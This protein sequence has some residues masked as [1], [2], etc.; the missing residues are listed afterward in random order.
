MSLINIKSYTGT[1]L[2]LAPRVIGRLSNAGNPISSKPVN[3][4]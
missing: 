1:S 4:A 3:Y 2:K